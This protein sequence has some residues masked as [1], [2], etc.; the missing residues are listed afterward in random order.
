MQRVVAPLL[1]AYEKLPSGPQISTVSPGHTLVSG[2]LIEQ[3][4]LPQTRTAESLSLTSVGWPL[5]THG[6]VNEPSTLAPLVTS[7]ERSAVRPTRMSIVQ[8]APSARLNG[9]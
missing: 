4:M 5:L 8:F 2:A 7:P 1:Q 9:P 6:E 3:V